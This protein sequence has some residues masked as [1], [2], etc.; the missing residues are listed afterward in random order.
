MQLQS[1]FWMK[2]RYN[3]R[4]T[5]STKLVFKLVQKVNISIDLCLKPFRR[6]IISSRRFL[7]VTKWVKKALL[8]FFTTAL[9]ECSLQWAKYASLWG[10]PTWAW[11]TVYIGSDKN[12]AAWAQETWKND[13]HIP[14]SHWIHTPVRAKKDMDK[15]NVVKKFKSTTYWI[16]LNLCWFLFH[17][18]SRASP[19]NPKSFPGEDTNSCVAQRLQTFL[20]HIL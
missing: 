12:P 13:L 19:V 1:S 16:N 8:R 7:E 2:W 20:P 9:S 18:P 5:D 10:S 14:A 6:W 4:N 17:I 11:S 3:I 15:D